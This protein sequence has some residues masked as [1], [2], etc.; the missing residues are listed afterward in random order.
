MGDHG[1]SREQNFPD[2]VIRVQLII[3]AD[4]KGY[5]AE[6]KTRK[7]RNPLNINWKMT[8]CTKGFHYKCC[9]TFILLRL[10]REIPSR[11]HAIS[12]ILQSV[13][14]AQQGS[15]KRMHWLIH[16]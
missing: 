3:I 16:S 7:Y 8:H 11:Q 4:R 14:L 1:T 2:K 12:I 5:Q 13:T 6:K 15:F 10:K 9:D